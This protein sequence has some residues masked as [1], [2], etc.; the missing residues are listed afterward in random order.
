VWRPKRNVLAKDKYWFKYG[1][2]QTFLSLERVR[3][4]VFSEKGVTGSKYLN[5]K[6]NKVTHRK[7]SLVYRSD[8]IRCACIT[9]SSLQ[10]TKI[11]WF[12]VLR[13]V[14]RLPFV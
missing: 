9:I 3:K 8:Q 6:N 13:R 5:T 7:H 1:I 4:R 14:S 10:E 2:A 12:M 11:L